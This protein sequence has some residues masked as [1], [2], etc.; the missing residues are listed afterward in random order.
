MVGGGGVGVGGVHVVKERLCSTKSKFFPLRANPFLKG[1]KS[2]MEAS[3]LTHSW[4]PLS[5]TPSLA[6]N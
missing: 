6:V 5:Y 3:S 2:T 1:L 4:F